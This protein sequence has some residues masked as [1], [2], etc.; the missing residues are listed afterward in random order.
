[1]TPITV[2]MKKCSKATQTLRVGVVVRP[3]Q[4]QTHTQTGAITRV[5]ITITIKA[6]FK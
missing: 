5:I 1:M 6:F 4:K 2:I 3:T